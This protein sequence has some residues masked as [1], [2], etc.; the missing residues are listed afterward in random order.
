VIPFIILRKKKFDQKRNLKNLSL[1]ER[2]IFE[3]LREGATNQEISNQCLISINTVKSHVS[4]IYSK[5]NIKSRKD[6][7]NLEL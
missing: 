1:Q 3:F 7:M 6:L 4:N 2:R 5:L